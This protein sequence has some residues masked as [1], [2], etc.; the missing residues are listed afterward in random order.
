MQEA[1]M[2]VCRNRRLVAAVAVVAVAAY[3]VGFTAEPAAAAGNG[4][5]H[6]P[7]SDFL[8]TQG[9]T[10]VFIPPVPDYVGTS[11][12]ALN[13]FALIDYAGLAA[14]WIVDNG[15][16][17]LGTTV[18]GTVTERALADGRARV[19][20]HLRTT[21]ALSW[22]IEGFDFPN[23]PE[24]FGNRAQDVALGAEPALGHSDFKFEFINTAP[25]APIPDLVVAL[26]L[27]MP[28]PGFELRFLGFHCVAAGPL[29]DGSPAQMVDT[30][31]GIF[32]P[33]GHAFPPL[34]AFP[35]EHIFIHPVGGG[36]RGSGASA[37]PGTQASTWGAIKEV[38]R[39]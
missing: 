6:R 7:L 16:P 33:D 27:G 2:N 19:T 10:S 36:L 31:T 37:A 30:Q 24:I 14:Q 9:T 17:S 38:F 3:A 15:G 39:R 20:I 23:A 1:M 18:D 28:P 5:V 25:G 22:A 4:T 21:N 13:I 32:F 34:D 29:P 8:S 35:A 26:A 11:D 12:P